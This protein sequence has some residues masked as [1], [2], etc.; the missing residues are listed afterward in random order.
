M[1]SVYKLTY[2]AAPLN[3]TLI[4]RSHPIFSRPKRVSF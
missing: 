1:G 4:R 3:S 2:L